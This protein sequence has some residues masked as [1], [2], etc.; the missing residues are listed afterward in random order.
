MLTNYKLFVSQPTHLDGVL[1]DHE[2][3]ADSFSGHKKT[4]VIKYIYFSDHHA[5]ILHISPNKINVVNEDID[6]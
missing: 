1:L 4:I 3:I 6:L 2:Y 5:V